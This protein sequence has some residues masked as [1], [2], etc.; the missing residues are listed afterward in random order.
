[1]CIA[2]DCHNQVYARKLCT[3]HGGKRQCAVDGCVLH[4]R[5]GDV[6]S[7]HGS[8]GQA[9]KRCI[10]ADCTKLAIAKQL[11]VRHGGRRQCRVA[12]CGTHA[13][14][15]GFCRRHANANDVLARRLPP[16][17]QSTDHATSMELWG[18]ADLLLDDDA[19]WT[20]SLD[21]LAQMDTSWMNVSCHG[22]AMSKVVE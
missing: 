1:M 12:G 16:T 11:C 8:C 6:C 5:I 19:S 7:R 2:I 22:S 14:T 10:Y 21:Y 4:A 15:G 3:R 13:R 18:H 17:G 20:E 9:K